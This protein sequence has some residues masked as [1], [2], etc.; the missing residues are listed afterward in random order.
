VSR[1]QA[2]TGEG[3]VEPVVLG[4][5]PA[6]GGGEIVLRTRPHAGRHGAD[7]YELIVD[8]VFAMDTAE[9][10][11]ELQLA[12][13]T[14]RRLDGSAWRVLVGG[15]GLGFTLRELL[16]DQRVA[17]VEVVELE[18]ALID[19]IRAGLVAPA[20]GLLDDPRVEVLP[21]DVA[22]RIRELAAGSVD[23]ILLDVDNGPDF[24]VHAAN[25]ELYAP[26]MVRVAVHALRPAGLLAIWSAGPAPALLGALRECAGA[27]EDV[28]LRVSREGREL[29]YA[30]YLARR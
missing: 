24:L 30:L 9:V 19:W 5:R 17:E 3:Y 14:L 15:L 27:V 18:P 12:S 16:A 25:A 10:S 29:E 6:V 21:G 4:R 13:E 26:A 20:A 2:V 7:V 11:T 22:A 1:G 23:A 8:G 28:P